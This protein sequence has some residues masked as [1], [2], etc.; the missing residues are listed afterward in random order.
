MKT[1]ELCLVFSF[2]KISYLIEVGLLLEAVNEADLHFLKL[3]TP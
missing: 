1:K 3:N 2:P